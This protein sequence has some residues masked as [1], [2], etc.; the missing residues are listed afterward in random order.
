MDKRK[1]AVIATGFTGQQHVEAVRRIPGNEVAALVDSNEEALKAKAA[2][3]GVGRIYTDYRQ[4]IDETLRMWYI[5]ARP[6]A[7]TTVLINM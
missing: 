7:C 2:E 4:M 5:T 6:T 3:L 1:V